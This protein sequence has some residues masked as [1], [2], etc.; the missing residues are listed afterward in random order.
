[1]EGLEYSDEI[2]DKWLKDTLGQQEQG[3]A[4]KKEKTITKEAPTTKRRGRKK[5]EEEEPEFEDF[6]E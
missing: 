5:K 3:N 2:V 1:M 4:E 6:S